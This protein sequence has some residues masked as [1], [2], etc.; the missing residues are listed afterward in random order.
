M[1][2][3]A[4]VGGSPPPPGRFDAPGGPSPSAP[5]CPSIAHIEEGLRPLRS[6][7]ERRA[8]RLETCTSRVAPLRP[9]RKQES[10]PVMTWELSH[11]PAGAKL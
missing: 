2:A 10:D 3:S 1:I 11:G 8:L 4:S 9:K 7:W 5:S 6:F